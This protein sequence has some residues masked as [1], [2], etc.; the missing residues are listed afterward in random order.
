MRVRLKQWRQR[1]LLTQS[2]L[3]ERVGMTLGTINRI[4]RGVHEPRFSTI[5][6]LAI[7]LDATPDDL[8][9]DEPSVQLDSQHDRY[10]VED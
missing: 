5:R 10:W 1:R 2:E 9:V 4:E 3:A 6:K 8:V 7:A